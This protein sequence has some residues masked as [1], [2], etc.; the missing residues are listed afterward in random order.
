MFEAALEKI[1]EIDV[2][3]AL[4]KPDVEVDSGSLWSHVVSKLEVV[5][6]AD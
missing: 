5:V 4:G 1:V 3:F 2:P 6:G